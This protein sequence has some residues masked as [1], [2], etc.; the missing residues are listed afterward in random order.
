MPRRGRPSAPTGR[1][2]RLLYL[3]SRYF[4]KRSGGSMMCMSQS[5][6][7]SPSFMTPS[8]VDRVGSTTRVAAPRWRRFYPGSWRLWLPR[9]RDGPGSSGMPSQP[10]DVLGEPRVEI[11]ARPPAEILAQA[12]ASEG[13]P[14]EI[15]GPEP[16]R[17]LIRGATPPRFLG[18]MRTSAPTASS[19][20]RA[21][22][23]ADVVRVVRQGGRRA[24]PPR[25]R[26]QCR[27]HRRCH[28][29]T[30]GRR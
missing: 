15:A 24:G 28:A 30:P 26:Q 18:T 1:S 8:C 9:C 22:A 5:T 4:S 2:T 20:R 11:V 19:R 12:I 16:G 25:C 21:V 6:N 14:G 7:L 23:P 29:R 3:G 27:R 17:R 13:A 10:L